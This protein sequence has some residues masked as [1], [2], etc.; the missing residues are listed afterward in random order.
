MRRDNS[1]VPPLTTTQEVPMP[2]SPP[3]TPHTPKAPPHRKPVP[4]NDDTRQMSVFPPGYGMGKTQ[5]KPT[6]SHV[7]KQRMPAPLSSHPIEMTTSDRKRPPTPETSPSTI[8]RLPWEAYPVS[9][10]A[11][12]VAQQSRHRE[13]RQQNLP[14]NG[15]HKW[16]DSLPRPKMMAR[17][18]V[19]NLTS[20]SEDR[21][22]AGNGNS[23]ARN[24]SKSEKRSAGDAPV[25]VGVS[26]WKAPWE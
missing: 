19:P 4:R 21:A 2:R 14:P 20:R 1:L 10:P 23:R 8:R 5:R 18:D 16:A 15:T 9:A 7:Q 24:G 12:A 25:F 3:K 13:E 11:S 22:V 26:D 6:P 17:L